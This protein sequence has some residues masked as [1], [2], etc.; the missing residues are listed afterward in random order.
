MPSEVPSMTPSTEPSSAPSMNPSDTPGLGVCAEENLLIFTTVNRSGV[1]HIVPSSAQGTVIGSLGGSKTPWGLAFDK[2]T[3]FFYT[4]ASAG[5]KLARV[6]P[7]TGNLFDVKSEIV[8]QA[9]ALGCSPTGELF[10]VEFMNG[11]SFCFFLSQK[12][13][14]LPQ[15]LF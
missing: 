8:P 5:T 4:L 7:A 1:G 10:G 13:F 14:Y 6:D 11:V 12:H 9:F 3:G 2:N 15:S